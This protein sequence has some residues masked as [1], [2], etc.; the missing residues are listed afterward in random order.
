MSKPVQQVPMEPD[1]RGVRQVAFRALGTQCAIQFRCEDKRR[2]LEFVADALGWL[3]SFEAKFSRFKPSSLI[4]RIN[5]AAGRDWVPVDADT[6][7]MLDLADAMHRLTDGVL[8]AAMLP[9]IKVWDWKVVHER[10]PDQAEITKAMSLSNWKDVQRKPGSVFLSHEGMG[11]D[12]GGFGKEYAVDQLIAIARKHSISDALVDL[13]RDIFAIGGNGVHPFWH[14]GIQDGVQTERCT[15][16]LAVSNYAVCA[17]GDYARRFEHNG[18]RYGHIL[19]RRT[20]WPVRHGL[21]AVTVIAPSC[22]LAGIYSTAVFVLGLRDG[23]R[24][25]ENAKGV[26]ACAQDDNGLHVSREFRRFQVQAA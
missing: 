2:A 26:E 15:G 18:V 10:L 19:D 9:L 22:L 17:S 5:Q 21:R 8:D 4:S 11:L 25:I 14:V 7:K 3:S 20:G 12:F 1:A 13:G 24:L 6:E 23:L 16:G